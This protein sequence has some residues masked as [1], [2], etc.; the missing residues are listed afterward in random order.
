[1]PIVAMYHVGAWGAPYAA[2][3]TGS[4][5][6]LPG[7]GMSGAD[8][9]ELITQE[10]VTVALGVPTIWLTLHNH[11]HANRLQVP[12]LARVCVGGRSEERRVG[13]EGR[14]RWSGSLEKNDGLLSGR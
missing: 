8:M 12:T 7:A 11:L 5:L 10:H 13:K 14:S 2:L 3:L 9:Y 1:M 4:K 6:V